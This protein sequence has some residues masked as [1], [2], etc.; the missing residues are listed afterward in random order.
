MVVVM[1]SNVQGSVKKDNPP[2]GYIKR[3][4]PACSTVLQ[5][6]SVII[7]FLFEF[8]ITLSINPIQYYFTA[9]QLS[10]YYCNTVRFLALY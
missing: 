2:L 8:C 10:Y 5:T 6:K 4:V 1:I 7:V 9:N 3:M